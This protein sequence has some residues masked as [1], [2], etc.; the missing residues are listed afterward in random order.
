MSV[1]RSLI[2][3]YL[4]YSMEMK[5]EEDQA[6]EYYR[7]AADIAIQNDNDAVAE[8]VFK[9]MAEFNWNRGNFEQAEMS[10]WHEIRCLLSLYGFYN[11]KTIAC[12]EQY[13]AGH[14]QTRYCILASHPPMLRICLCPLQR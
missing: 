9:D 5:K 2:Y 14:N 6:E 12:L 3:R 4:A 7:M 10:Y 8:R 13:S 1:A 11:K